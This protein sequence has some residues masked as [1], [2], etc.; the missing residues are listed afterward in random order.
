MTEYG[1]N[2]VITP[3]IF[4]FGM[5]VIGLLRSPPPRYPIKKRV[6]VSPR[7]GVNILEMGKKFL[8][9][10]GDDPRLFAHPFR[11]LLTMLNERKDFNGV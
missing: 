5:Q 9:H 6:M 1:E 11:I 7:A 4:N 3:G 2:R 8:A 10:T